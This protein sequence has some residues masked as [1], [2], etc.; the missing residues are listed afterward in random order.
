[1][2]KFPPEC[3][4]YSHDSTIKSSM[5]PS[6]QTPWREIQRDLVTVCAVFSWGRSYFCCLMDWILCPGGQLTLFLTLKGIGIVMDAFW[7]TIKLSYF[8]QAFF[9]LILLLTSIPALE[10][11]GSQ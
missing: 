4:K 2:I 6:T 11:C 10:M 7:F 8:H 3:I 1:M 9:L 5:T